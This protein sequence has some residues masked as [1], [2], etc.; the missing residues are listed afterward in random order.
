MVIGLNGLM[1]E[2]APNW[3]IKVGQNLK[4]KDARI[5]HRSMEE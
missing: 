1:L 3:E 4:R 5:Q 2:A